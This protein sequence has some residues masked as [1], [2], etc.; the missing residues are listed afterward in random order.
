M[1][2]EPKYIIFDEPT[3]M[4]DPEGKEAVYNI[5][6]QLKEKKYTIIY[7][8][9][10]TDE[11]LLSD[12]IVVIED[13]EIINI[14]AKKDILNQIDFLKEHGIKI[15]FG[16]ELISSLK[17]NGVNIEIDDWDKEEIMKKIIEVAK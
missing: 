11:I 3:T 12:R 4:I 1:V 17:N 16:V 6:K 9:N 15:P 5:I 14:F 13:G 8:T 7:I 2:A 10:F